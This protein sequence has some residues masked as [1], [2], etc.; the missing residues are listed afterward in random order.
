MKIK[1]H[2]V[3]DDNDGHEETITDVAVL[4]KTCQ[5]LE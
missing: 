3:I 1:V 5:Q 4:E 2:P